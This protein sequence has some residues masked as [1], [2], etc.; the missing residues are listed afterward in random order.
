MVYENTSLSE[1]INLLFLGQCDLI[2]CHTAKHCFNLCK[3]SLGKGGITQ[4]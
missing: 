4:T 1:S 2:T 3:N